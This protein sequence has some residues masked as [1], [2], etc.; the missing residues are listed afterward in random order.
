MFRLTCIRISTVGRVDRIM[1]IKR[2]RKEKKAYMAMIFVD[3]D[4]SA[5][6][7]GIFKV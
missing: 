4:R 3:S 7:A 5:T 1:Q 2:R 6:A